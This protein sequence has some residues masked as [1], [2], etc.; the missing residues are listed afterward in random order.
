METALPIEEVANQR[1]NVLVNA[2]TLL[3]K[4]LQAEGVARDKVKAANDKT[5]QM[6][7]RAAGEQFK[8]LTAGAAVTDVL[9]DAGTIA[10]S[11]HGMQ[12]QEERGAT[13]KRVKIEK[14][15]WHEASQTYNLPDD[16]RFCQSGHTAFSNTMLQT[17][18]PKARA[19]VTQSLVAGDPFCDERVT[20]G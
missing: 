9:F 16:W 12:F 10:A 6:L 19:E 5:W 20:A 15:P 11:I 13:E 3:I 8:A 1:L 17:I 14:C 4:N 18:S 2:Y 7:G